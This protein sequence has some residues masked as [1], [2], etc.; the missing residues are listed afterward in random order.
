MPLAGQTALCESTMNIMQ[1]IFTAIFAKFSLAVIRLCDVGLC[2][3]PCVIFIYNYIS[4]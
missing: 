2:D 1:F 4:V 3:T